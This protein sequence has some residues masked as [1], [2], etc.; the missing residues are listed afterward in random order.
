M[1]RKDLERVQVRM[2]ALF[3]RDCSLISF[4]FLC[5]IFFHLRKRAII[6]SH[7]HLIA[8]MPPP[9]E[10][11][12]VIFNMN[13]FGLRNMDWWAV[14]F[15]VKTVE[16]YYPESL[17]RIYVHGAPWF[18]KPIWIILRPLL[19]PIVRDKVRLTSSVE[20]LEDHIPWTHLPKNSM[21]GGMEWDYV[22][23]GEL[24]SSSLSSFDRLS[25]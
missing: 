23:P 16:A 17:T 8:L 9:V 15:L 19:D 10:K 25:G 12:V 1:S 21:F 6:L 22:Y 4:T 14:F 13:H 7:E 3:S 18:F 5:P 20:E 11:C 2:Y 24:H